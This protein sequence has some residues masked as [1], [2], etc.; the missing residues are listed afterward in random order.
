M[1]EV[2]HV[3]LAALVRRQHEDTE[4]VQELTVVGVR[5]LDTTGKVEP[6][7]TFRRDQQ[8]VRAQLVPDDD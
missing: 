2:L 8:I 4:A 6:K 3:A 5:L 7:G 1:Q